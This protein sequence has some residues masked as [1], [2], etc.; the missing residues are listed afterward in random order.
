MD[1]GGGG[2][3]VGGGRGDR[4]GGGDGSGGGGGGE[5]GAD[6]TGGDGGGDGGGGEGPARISAVLVGAVS[7]DTVR[8]PPNQTDDMVAGVVVVRSVLTAAATPS[9]SAMMPTSRSTEPAL[10][11]ATTPRTPE[12][13]LVM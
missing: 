1:G 7:E 11:L 6:G 8:L 10:R 4:L 13:A 3:E 2:D 12:C 5:G 9:P